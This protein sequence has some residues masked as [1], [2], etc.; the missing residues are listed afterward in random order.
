MRV[1]QLLTALSYGDAIGDDTLAIQRILRDAG[2]ESDIFCQLH[3]PRM[4]SHVKRFELYRKIS[5]PN[6]IIIFHFSIGSPVSHIVPE[7]SDRKIMI[8]HNITPMQYFLD[9]NMLLAQLCYLGRRELRGFA[10]VVDLGLGDSDFNR[11]EL[12]ESGF[13]PTGVLPIIVDF[14]KFR[15]ESRMPHRIHGDSGYTFVFVG[16][17]I[18]NKKIEEV[19]RVFHV[20]QKWHNADSRLFIVGDYQGF[21]RYY[22]ALKDFV[23]ELGVQRVHFTGHVTN[24]EVV[25][26]YRMSDLFICM[27]EHEGFCVPLLEAFH[28]GLPVIAWQSSAVGETLRGAGILFKEK[29]YGAMA[30][31]AETLRRDKDFRE[32]ILRGQREVLA[33]YDP[34]ITGRLLLDYVNQVAARI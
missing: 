2:H 8:Y 11:R 22:W 25:A 15:R 18:P 10:P 12:E 5:S 23:A 24:E 16:R 33:S 30:K 4:A 34:A 14:S 28:F 20:Y 7:L 26:Y 9:T 21:E 29:D 19:I 3:H 31:A 6:N 17:I 32:E 13:S 27:S 1:H